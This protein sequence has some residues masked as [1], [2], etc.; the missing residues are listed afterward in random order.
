MDFFVTVPRYIEDKLFEELE[1]LGT[2]ELRKHRSGCSFSGE[3]CHAYTIILNSR[4]AARVHAVITTFNFTDKDDFYEGIKAINWDEHFG[5]ENTILVDAVTGHPK[6]NHSRYVE[7]LTKDGI[8]DWFRE[9]Y[10]DRP[11]VDVKDPD[12]RLNIKLDQSSAQVSI[13]LSGDSLHKRGYRDDRGE[14]LLKENLAAAILSSMDWR[15]EIDHG[16]RFVD[17]LCGG[18]TFVLEAAMSYYKIPPSVCRKKFGFTHWKHHD[19]AIYDKCLSEVFSEYDDNLKPS[20]KKFFGFDTNPGKIN[21]ALLS[22]ENLEIEDKVHFQVQD[23]KEINLA[24]FTENKGCLFINPPYGKRLLDTKQSLSMYRDIKNFLK[25]YCRNWKTVILC[26]QDHAFLK[27][28]KHYVKIPFYN[29]EIPIWALCRFGGGKRNAS[30]VSPNDS[31]ECP[32]NSQTDAYE[33]FQENTTSLNTDM[34][35]DQMTSQEE[36][37]EANNDYQVYDDK[38]YAQI[39]ESGFRDRLEKNFKKFSKTLGKDGNCFRVYDRDIPEYA[40]S[41][42][43]FGNRG[44]ISEFRP[45]QTVDPDK[46]QARFKKAFNETSQ[47]L[48]IPPH[49]LKVKQ[50]HI[51]KKGQLYRKIS[52][53]ND[54]SVAIEN[55]IKFE[56]NTSDYLDCGLFLDQRDV[57][58]WIKENVSGKRFLNLFS[59]TSTA[60]VYAIAGQAASTTSV[61]ASG[62]Y[63]KWSEKNLRLNGFQTGRNHNFVKDDCF[64]FLKTTEQRY[65]LIFL[66]PPA[67]SSNRHLNQK[68]NIQDD[69]HALIRLSMNKLAE[70]G[71]LIFSV[72]Q[73][74]FQL[75]E[76]LNRVYEIEDIS[77]SKIPP[78]FKRIGN[79]LKTF[80]ITRPARSS[81]RD[82]RSD[83]RPFRDNRSFN[84]NR[85][86][87]PFQ[88]D[89]P[90][91]GSFQ[92]GR[93]HV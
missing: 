62:T 68:F 19:K 56:V 71:T 70:G 58:Q 83:G 8:V 47:V 78:D 27:E 14:N 16:G 41:I 30:A 6:L 64:K 32:D 54:T 77:E 17:F 18:G 67:F 40:L 55:N 91:G 12:I 21:S 82:D 35:P 63:I 11:S 43:V 5:A 26:P 1:A 49:L 60:T 9:K 74:K 42:D 73:Q 65:D 36:G 24:F 34:A 3:L 89:R 50:R 13:D 45:P 2:P 38:E 57:R 88:K 85:G 33:E 31:D 90:E 87:R 69:H 86:G 76:D 72:F 23:Y 79:N 59:Y 4:L 28:A 52:E 37:T 39:P 22:A 20:K 48:G 10:D 7:Q 92:I 29:G 53:A 93:A 25:L 66:S 84:D 75:N 80:L 46:A 44:I 81:Y 51:Q 61:D 15:Q